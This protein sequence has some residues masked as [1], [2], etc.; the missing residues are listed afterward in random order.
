MTEHK[1]VCVNSG[2]H[3][4]ADENFALTGYYAA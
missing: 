1:I 4:E 3:S 2:F